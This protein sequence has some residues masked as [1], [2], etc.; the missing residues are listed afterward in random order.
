MRFCCMF[1]HLDYCTGHVVLLR[2]QCHG[3]S[4]T[5]TFLPNKSLFGW[6]YLIVPDDVWSVEAWVKIIMEAELL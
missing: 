1:I 6:R 3:N 4:F 5:S 2:V